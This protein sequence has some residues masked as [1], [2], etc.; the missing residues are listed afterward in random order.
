MTKTEMDIRL[1]KIFS[2]AA[3]AQATLINELCANSS[4]SLIKRRAPVVFTRWPE[5]PARCAGN[6][7]LNCSRPNRPEIVV[8]YTEP[9]IAMAIYSPLL[10]PIFWLAACKAVGPV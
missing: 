10:A 2:A 7:W 3:I 8:G 9:G 5:K 4:N 1:T 6:W